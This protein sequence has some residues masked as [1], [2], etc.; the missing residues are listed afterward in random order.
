[1]SSESS[2]YLIDWRPSRLLC[3]ALVCLGVLA[4][5]SFWLSALP[6]PSKTPLALL[7]LGHGLWLAW[8]EAHRP[9]FSLCVAADGARLVMI[10]SDRSQH[11]SAP[12][13]LVRG[14]L[15]CVS[16][17]GED[18]RTRWL[19]WWPDT[20]PAPSRRALRLTSG[21]RMVDSGPALATMAG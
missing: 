10:F 3:S 18:G 15:A 8:R 13:V 6:L 17:R 5:I 12:T 2:S 11:L 19:L 9:I 21:K 20:L 1:M 7:A 16:G 14:P 4:A